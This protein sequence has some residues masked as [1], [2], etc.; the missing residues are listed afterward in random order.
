M[1]RLVEQLELSIFVGEPSVW[2]IFFRPVVKFLIVVYW[3]NKTLQCDNVFIL[4]RKV[5]AAKVV[6]ERFGSPANAGR[7]QGECDAD[8]IFLS[9]RHDE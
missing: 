3:K 8:A 7:V 9:Y 2:V 5:W 6:C 1:R 4:R